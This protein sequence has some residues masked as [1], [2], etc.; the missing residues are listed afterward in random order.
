[1]TGADVQL[2][3]NRTNTPSGNPVPDVAGIF[4]AALPGA[5]WK[6][7]H[8]RNEQ[9]PPGAIPPVIQHVCVLP[10][11]PRPA[12]PKPAALPPKPKPERTLEERIADE[13]ERRLSDRA[14]NFLLGF[15]LGE[16]LGSLWGKH[17]RK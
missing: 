3:S 4:F 1:V 12:A 16:L 13:V 8:M 5:F 2:Q 9:A 15:L 11:K 6:E 17:R 7:T 14:G 10:A